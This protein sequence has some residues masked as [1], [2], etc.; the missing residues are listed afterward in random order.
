MGRKTKFRKALSMPGLLAEMRRCFEGV[1]DE[2]AGRRKKNDCER[3]EGRRQRTG[4]E[5]QPRPQRCG[6]KHERLGQDHEGTA[7]NMDSPLLP[8]HRT[9]HGPP[10]RNGIIH[11]RY[12]SR[13][14]RSFAPAAGSTRARNSLPVPQRTSHSPT[15]AKPSGSAI[16]ASTPDRCSA[17]SSPNRDAA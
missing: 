9:G 8:E 16:R 7:Y 4:G 1:E 17:V 6:A 10:P 14:P 5:R 12:S 2:V 13:S 15:S 11:A 3:G